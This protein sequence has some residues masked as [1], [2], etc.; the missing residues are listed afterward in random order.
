MKNDSLRWVIHKD[1]PPLT[2]KN[3]VPYIRGVAKI[4]AE[5]TPRCSVKG[6]GRKADAVWVIAGLGI[7]R[8]CKRHEKQRGLGHPPKEEV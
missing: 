2:P 6:C 7:T 4:L 1:R 8:F 3:I 5:Q